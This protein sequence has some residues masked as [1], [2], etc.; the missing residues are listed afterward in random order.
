M[1]KE[2][3]DPGCL[4]CHPPVTKTGKVITE[5]ELEAWAAEAE[6]GYNIGRPEAD[7]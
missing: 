4:I 5:A 2:C 7:G 1:R 6:A 3:G